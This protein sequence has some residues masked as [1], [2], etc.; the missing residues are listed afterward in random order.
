MR[1]G[2]YKANIILTRSAQS[3]KKTHSSYKWKNDH[4]LLILLIFS[5]FPPFARVGDLKSQRIH[6][7]L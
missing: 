6:K 3:N 1:I 4:T 5:L 7:V 2:G